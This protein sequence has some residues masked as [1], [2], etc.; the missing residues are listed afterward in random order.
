VLRQISRP[1]LRD[2]RSET[3]KIVE[4]WGYQREQEA[5]ELRCAICFQRIALHRSLDGADDTEYHVGD[6]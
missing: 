3:D 6:Y 1:L 2:W 5:D 4:T